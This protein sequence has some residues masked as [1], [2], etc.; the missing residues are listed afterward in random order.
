MGLFQRVKVHRIVYSDSG[1][2]LVKK[3][4]GVGDTKL[5]LEKKSSGNKGQAAGSVA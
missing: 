3:N 4:S 5:K 1:D 2:C